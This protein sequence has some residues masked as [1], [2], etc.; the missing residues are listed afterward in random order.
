MSQFRY[1]EAVQI[2]RMFQR[3]CSH[4]QRNQVVEL[5]NNHFILQVEELALETLPDEACKI[6][7]PGPYFTTHQLFF[8]C[9][10]YKSWANKEHFRSVTWVRYLSEPAVFFRTVA[11]QHD[12]RSC[13]H[14]DVETSG[15]LVSGRA[16]F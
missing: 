16:F 2:F 14:A 3:V 12:V 15:V 8:S 10:Q 11:K 13:R 6:G 9:Q 1:Y 5:K 4:E 7:S